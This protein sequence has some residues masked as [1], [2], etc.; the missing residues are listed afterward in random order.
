MNPQNYHQVWTF[1]L[2]ICPLFI[3][4]R[5]DHTDRWTRPQCHNV[6]ALNRVKYSHSIFINPVL[7]Y[8]QWTINL[9]KMKSLILLISLTLAGKL[10]NNA[11]RM[12]HQ[13]GYQQTSLIS[14]D[15]MKVRKKYVLKI[16]SKFFRIPKHSYNTAHKETLR[17][18][19]PACRKFSMI[20]FSGS[21]NLGKLYCWYLNQSYSK[22]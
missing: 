17:K 9:V 6:T 16:N 19:R 18:K 22:Y 1:S 13:G 20:T 11:A 7:W 12:S 5:F 10:S 8:A 3:L 14:S 15:A 21:S 4:R 2:H